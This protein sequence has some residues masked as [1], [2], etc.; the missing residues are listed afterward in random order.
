M[1]LHDFL[2]TL[3]TTNRAP[4]GAIRISPKPRD[5]LNSHADFLRRYQHIVSRA[6]SICLT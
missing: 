2:L 6:F 1:R 4:D 3:A 5:P